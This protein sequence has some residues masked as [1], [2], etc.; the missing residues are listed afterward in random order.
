MNAKAHDPVKDADPLTAPRAN[1][2][3]IKDHGDDYPVGWSLHR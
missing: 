3:G 2:R 1:N